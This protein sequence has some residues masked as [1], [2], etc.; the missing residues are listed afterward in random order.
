MRISDIS[1]QLDVRCAMYPIHH[2]L[3]LATWLLITCS[4][5]SKQLPLS[6]RHHRLRHHLRHHHPHC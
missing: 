5:P 6:S 4:L 2:L 1:D 3:L